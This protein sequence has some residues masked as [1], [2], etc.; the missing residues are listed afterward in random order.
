MK[1]NIPNQDILNAS[2]VSGKP[3]LL[4]GGEGT[5]FRIDD[6]VLKPIQ[7]SIEV[8]W[9]ADI[10]ERSYLEHVPILSSKFIQKMIMI[11]YQSSLN[12]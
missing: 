10:C 1:E 4:T 12:T 5:C 3:V 6:V 9:I 2:G 8:S 7:N 11:G